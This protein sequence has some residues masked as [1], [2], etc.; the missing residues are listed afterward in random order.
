MMMMIIIIVIIIIII[1]I[2]HAWSLL[3]S[4]KL[5]LNLWRP[6]FRLLYILC[7]KTIFGFYPFP[8]KLDIFTA[9]FI[10]EF[11]YSD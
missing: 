8:A 7:V 5:D 2:G 9:I 3:S 11:C 4:W 6:L 1:I 10:L